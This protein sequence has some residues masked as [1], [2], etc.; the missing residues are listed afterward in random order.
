MRILFVDSN[1]IAD[2]AMLW[3]LVEMELDVERA[4]TKPDINSTS[5][6]M[7]NALIK[8]LDGFDV[9]MSQN[10]I[11]DL[12]SA[13]QLLGKKYISWIYDSPQMSLFR[14]EALYDTNHIF[15]F[16]KAGVELLNKRG[17]NRVTHYPLAANMSQASGLYI[18][19][20]DI[21]KYT[22]DVS[23]VGSLY[24]RD[25]VD[26]LVAGLSPL[27]RAD[28]DAYADEH[29]CR[30]TGR[31]IASATFSDRLIGEL[32]K[33][34]KQDTFNDYDVDRD[35]FT[36][37]LVAL[38]YMAHLERIHLINRAADRYNTRLYTNDAMS[39][40]VRALVCP[41]VDSETDMYKVFYSSKINLNITHRG[42]ITGL[43]QRIFDI[44]SVGGFVFTNYQAELDDYFREGNDIEC[45]RDVKE[46][47]D[48]LGYYLSHDNERINI[49]INGYKKVR[50]LFNC[51]RALENILRLSGLM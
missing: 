22:C 17:F 21:E 49:A 37:I 25:H 13:C 46:F 26:K 42:I 3:G 36:Q 18:S 35:Y 31:N 9:A 51:R 44:A 38:P 11:P 2:N 41:P 6:Q 27:A 34:V 12:A 4:I 10:F 15:M 29:I 40:Q 8:E 33:S 7:V 43:P 50:D 32:N 23:F 48:K 39:Q 28:L 24:S 20:E 1:Q 19:D 5:S 45:F 47:D 16:D 14:K 30:F